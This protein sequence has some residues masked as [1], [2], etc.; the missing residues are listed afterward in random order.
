MDRELFERIGSFINT[1]A[2]AFDNSRAHHLIGVK[3]FAELRLELNQ[4]N[5][6]TQHA[7]DTEN[8]RR[9]VLTSSHSRL[10]HECLNVAH[11]CQTAPANICSLMPNCF[12]ASTRDACY[13]MQL[14]D[15][16]L[17]HQRIDALGDT[18][19]RISN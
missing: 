17:I 2:L 16:Y 4:L 11:A 7:L 10:L 8:N 5:R 15:N 9:L 6:T 1:F 19:M 18:R 12:P 13:A 14:F 3:R